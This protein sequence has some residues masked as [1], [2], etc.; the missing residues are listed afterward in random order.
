MNRRHV[1]TAPH[2]ERSVMT[3]RLLKP[4]THVARRQPVLTSVRA[5][6]LLA[7]IFMCLPVFVLAQPEGHAR[8]RSTTPARLDRHR[9]RKGPLSTRYA[10]W[11]SSI[12]LASCFSRKPVVSWVAHSSA[13]TADQFGCRRR[14]RMAIVVGSTTSAIQFTVPR[15][16]SFGWITKT[17]PTTPASDGRRTTGAAAV[18]P[19]HGQRHTAFSSSLGP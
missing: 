15:P 7:L 4:P 11:C 12:R 8:T 1:I 2:N 5:T 9:H 19:L 6:A 18:A 14:G 3:T 10:Y 13:I 16:A 17:V